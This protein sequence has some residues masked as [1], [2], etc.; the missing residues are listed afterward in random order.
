VKNVLFIHR[1]VGHNLIHD[2]RVYALIEAAEQPFELSDYNHNTGT[3]T[4][5]A[6]IKKLNMQFPGG[7]TRPENYAALFTRKG[8]SEHRELLDLMGGYDTVVLKSCYPTSNIR[9]DTELETIKQ[10]YRTITKFFT[11]VPSQQLVLVTSPPLR[12]RKTS[13]DNARRARELATWLSNNQ[14]S[15]NVHVFDL[16]NLLA[17]PENH[18]QANTLRKEYRRPYFWDSHPSATASQKVAPKFV[19]FLK[20]IN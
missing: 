13:K 3:L 6:G 19:E 10:H 14:F 1:S 15:R 16:F 4:S 8:S 12:S 18:A 11:G 17:H 7:D 9:N 20:T 2:G 5:P